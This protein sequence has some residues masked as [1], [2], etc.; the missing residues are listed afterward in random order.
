MLPEHV[1]RAWKDADYRPDADAFGADIPPNPAGSI[2]LPDSAL[3]VAG[4]DLAARTEYLESLGC[5]QGFTQA[6]RCDFTAGPIGFCT[7]FCLTITMSQWDWC[8]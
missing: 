4:G 3:D 7:T 5:C 1:I 8:Q 2:N 6:T